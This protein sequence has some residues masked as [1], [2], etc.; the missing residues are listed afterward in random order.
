MKTLEQLLRIFGF[1]A[2]PSNR[3]RIYKVALDSIGIDASPNDAAPDELGCA[4]TVWNII[5]KAC[6][7]KMPI[8]ISTNLMYR[9]FKES[10][11]YI[12]IDVPM[13]G[14]IIMS[15][16]G[17]G[18]GFLPNGHVGIVGRVDNNDFNNTLVMSN[19][20]STG[21]FMQNFTIGSWKKRYIEM[22]GYPVWYFRRV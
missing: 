1:A 11:F 7:A 4:D 12:K 6:G 10:P 13:E 9:R 15:P 21:K 17:F 14:D 18:N 8:T 22:G 2:A 16:T 20:S 5:Q 3:L 19:S